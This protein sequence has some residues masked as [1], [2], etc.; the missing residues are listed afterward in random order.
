MQTLQKYNTTLNRCFEVL[1]GVVDGQLQEHT[2]GINSVNTANT[3]NIKHTHTLF[4][5][6]SSSSAP[7]I[8]TNNTK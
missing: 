4:S 3:Y 8:V 2:S 5:L 1:S 6:S 7:S